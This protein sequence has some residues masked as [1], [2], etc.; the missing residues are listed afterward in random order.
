[1]KHRLLYLFC[2]VL[3]PA[4]ACAQTADFTMA[5]QVLRWIKTSQTDSLGAVMTEKMKQQLPPAAMGKIWGQL[6]QSAGSLQGTGEWTEKEAQGYRLQE[7]PLQFEKTT[8]KISITLDNENKVAGLFFAP[9]ETQKPH[10]EVAHLDTV[11]KGC[12]QERELTIASGTLSLPATLCLPVRGNAPHPLVVLVHGSGPNDRN[13]SLGPNRMFCDVA[14]ALAA[15]GIASI[16]YDKRTF[17]YRNHPE[18]A[19]PVNNYDD[20]TTNDAVA[21]LQY[22]ASLPEADS[23]RIFILGHSLGGALAPR[24]AARCPFQ[25]AGLIGWSAPARALDVMLREQLHHLAAHEGKSAE[26]ADSAAAM[27]LSSLPQDYLEMA[28]NYN[29][30]QQARRLPIPQLYL[31]GGHDYQVTVTDFELWKKGLGANEGRTERPGMGNFRPNRL[32]DNMEARNRD[33]GERPGFSNPYVVRPA[34]LKNHRKR[35]NGN[36][37]LPKA[38]PPKAH[39]PKFVWIEQGDHLLRLTEQM[40]TPD[41]YH[42]YAPI[43]QEAMQAVI[44]FIQT[45]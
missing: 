24:I 36:G 5:H 7:C 1:M 30:V 25:P 21:V 13:E 44:Q 9:A 32:G 45:P 17:V 16:R 15:Q 12:Y 4:W 10:T 2:L 28:R 43:S 18:A 6:T 38:Q 37:T 22:A 31:G 14:H 39:H 27:V 11:G 34:W 29:P 26:F 35:E 8:L 33:R 20:E 41:S 3:L 23:T 42:T 19:G 40:A